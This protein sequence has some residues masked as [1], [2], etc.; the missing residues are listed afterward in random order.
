MNTEKYRI[1]EV[2][3]KC[4]QENCNGTL[5]EGYKIGDGCSCHINPPCSY[6][7]QNAVKCDTC[8]YEGNEHC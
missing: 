8:D 7:C 3:D 4:P 6:C 2:G 5:I 1:P